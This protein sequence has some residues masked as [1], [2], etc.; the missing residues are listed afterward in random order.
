MRFIRIPASGHS[1]RHDITGSPYQPDELGA[2]Q[3]LIEDWYQIEVLEIRFK[4]YEILVEDR[5]FQKQ[6]AKFF[7]ISS[8]LM[9][10]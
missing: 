7:F 10:P 8:R 3:D 9:A 1:G 4:I 2:R 5:R 6:C